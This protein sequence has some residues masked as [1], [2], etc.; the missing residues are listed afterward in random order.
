MANLTFLGVELY[1]HSADL[2]SYDRTWCSTNTTLLYEGSNQN[3]NNT[4]LT[5]P[6]TYHYKIFTK[7][8][9]DGT[10]YYSQGISASKATALAPPTLVS[11]SI[12]NI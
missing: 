7:Y 12:N 8:D 2:S 11:A 1:T 10:T 4:G 9:V 5:A 3:F 6:T